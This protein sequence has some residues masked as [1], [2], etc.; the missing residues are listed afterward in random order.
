MSAIDVESSASHASSSLF[1]ASIGEPK[2][3]FGVWM[4]SLAREEDGVM[5]G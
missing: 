4:I 3:H 2:S 1:G 5:V